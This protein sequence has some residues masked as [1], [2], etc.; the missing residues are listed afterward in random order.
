MHF[1]PNYADFF[2]KNCCRII[3]KSL[4]KMHKIEIREFYFGLNMLK[5]AFQTASCELFSSF[6]IQNIKNS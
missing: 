5:L 4:L 3:K 1:K 6:G 2:G